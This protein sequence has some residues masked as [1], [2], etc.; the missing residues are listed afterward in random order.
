[1]LLVVWSMVLKISF[2]LKVEKAEGS[3]PLEL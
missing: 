1:M 3:F 2:E